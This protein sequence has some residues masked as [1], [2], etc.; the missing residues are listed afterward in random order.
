MTAFQRYLL[1]ADFSPDDGARMPDEWRSYA[2]F[3]GLAIWEDSDWTH[4][5]ASWRNDSADLRPPNRG[6]FISSDVKAS[7]ART[8]FVFA[9]YDVGHYRSALSKYSLLL[10]YRSMH[11]RSTL[12]DSMLFDDPLDADRLINEWRAFDGDKE[13]FDDD[14]VLQPFVVFHAPPLVLGAS[15]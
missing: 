12:N 6:A 2:G 4:L 8:G 10:H 5:L 3:D 15:S 9:G 1:I 14:D 11:G 7:A 13:A